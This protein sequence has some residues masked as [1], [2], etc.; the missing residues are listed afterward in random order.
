[1]RRRSLLGGLASGALA[2]LAG[3]PG[4]LPSARADGRTPT[5]PG[6]AGET[7]LPV[8]SSAL[9]RSVPRDDIPAITDPAFGD[10]WRGIELEVVSEFGEE[11]TTKPRLS[12][13]SR[14]IGVARDGRA[15]AYPLKVLDW[16]EVVNDRFDGP[17]L[18][19]YCPLCRSGVTACRTVDGRVTDF[20]VDG[21]LWRSNLLL[22]DRQTDTLW[23]QI[24]ATA[25]R[26]QLTGEDLT[27]VPSALTTWGAWRSEHPATQVLLPPPF[28]DTIAGDD[29]V[30]RDYASRPYSRWDDSQE[31]GPGS[32]FDDDRL[33]PKAIVLGIAVDDD[34]TAY[35]LSDLSDAEVVNDTVGG[36][37]VVVT[38]T[39][40]E[41]LVAYYRA[42]DGERF[43]F[44]LAGDGTMR[45]G[46]SRWERSS[47]CVVDGPH[48]GTC[49]HRA[50]DLPPLFWFS[51]LDFNPETD[52]FAGGS[53]ANTAPM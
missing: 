2:G 7:D 11:Y 23:S 10:D 30:L 24:E 44:E 33:H 43:R 49:L 32:T 14:V 15:R 5:R 25:I 45:A 29:L 21:R 3:C 35:P 47:G 39:P 34:A 50:N 6:K 13:S 46:G 36:E 20:G 42:V 37:P 51:W 12:S 17:L 16:H 48:E 8:P 38:V 22:Y 41:R 27:V 9:V 1:M 18:V 40:D 31:V 4:R 28:S 52:L 53:E 19:T 26:G